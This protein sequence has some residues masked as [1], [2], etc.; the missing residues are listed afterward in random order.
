MLTMNGLDAYERSARLV[1]GLILLAPLV[2]VLVGFG[3]SLAPWSATVGGAI[4]ALAGPVVLAKHVGHRGRSLQD[5]LFESWGGPP[6]SAVLSPSGSGPVSP[7]LARRR[8]NVEAVTGI[9][10]PTTRPATGS[11]EAEI[12]HSAVLELRSRTNDQARFPR[13]SSENMN[14]GFERNLLG[15]KPEGLVVSSACLLALISG[16]IVTG[17]GNGHLSVVPLG[18]GA[19]LDT[20]LLVFWMV[21][22]TSA[23]VR[24]AGQRYAE[25]LIDSAAELR[26]SRPDG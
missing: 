25:R 6:T 19:T 4:L 5:Q 17:V 16:L 7:V 13:V 3:L 2:F 10:L 8:A 15:I 20:L 9:A 1:P 23:R 24:D 18:V 21:W 14:Y 22:P 11:D 12:Y 26:A